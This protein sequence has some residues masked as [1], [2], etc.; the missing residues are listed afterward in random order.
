MVRGDPSA[1]IPKLTGGVSG[2]K[3]RGGLLPPPQPPSPAGVVWSWALVTLT[4]A[5]LLPGIPTMAI[6]DLSSVVDRA[7]APDC[8][9]LQHDVVEA[10]LA[11]IGLTPDPAV[12][13]ILCGAC[14]RKD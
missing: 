13:C 11:R 1:A 4:T 3:S 7:R 2:R 9:H 8:V 14:P 6:G 10:Y 12:P 5:S